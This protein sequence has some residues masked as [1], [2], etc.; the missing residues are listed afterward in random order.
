[1]AGKRFHLGNGEYKSN[2]IRDGGNNDFV[3][4]RFEKLMFPPSDKEYT[5]IGQARSFD[6][7]FQLALNDAG[8]YGRITRVEDY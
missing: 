6:A 3:V 4:K 7:A 5:Y 8:Q 2:I 1:M